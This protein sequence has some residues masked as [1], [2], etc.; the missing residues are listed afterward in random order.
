MISLLNLNHIPQLILTSL[1][2]TLRATQ[3]VNFLC[4]GLRDGFHIGYSGP[5]THSFYPNLRSANLHPDIL[6]QNLLTEVLN[7]HT[8]GPF[9]SPPFINCRI[10]P[11]CLVPTKHSDKW[12]T[13]FHLSY[14]KN[15]S[16]SIN[17]NI[18]IEDYTLQYVTIDNAIHLLLSLGKGA[19]M[20]KTDIQSAFRII[21]ITPTTGNC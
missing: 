2:P 7:G 18:P 15:S 19:F 4:S 21:P 12:R 8:A 14:P 10:L 9:L 16:T 6:E 5:R 17:A 11:L 1:N 20:S 13:I 3:F